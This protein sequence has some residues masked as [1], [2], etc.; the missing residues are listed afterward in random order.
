MVYLDKLNISHVFDVFTIIE[1]PNITCVGQ[2][3]P[4]L[5][6]HTIGQFYHEIGDCII[7]LGDG[8]YKPE[9]EELQVKWPWPLQE[10][11]T[12]GQVHIVTN[13][14]TALNGINEIIEQGEG[15]GPVDP[16]DLKAGQLVHYYRFQEIVCGRKLVNVSKHEYAF[17]GGN[18]S[19]DPLGVWPMRQNL[20]EK[21]LFEELHAMLKQQVFIECFVLY[22][23]I[24]KQHLVVIP[25]T[26]SRLLS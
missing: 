10:N 20:G 7:T 2:R 18:I 25:Q 13:K 14:T 5:S 26:L 15:T 3:F 8:I 23:E 9:S 12:I 11:S 4:Q 19:Y 24:F 22:Y 17:K 21:E 6:N 1:A 16:D